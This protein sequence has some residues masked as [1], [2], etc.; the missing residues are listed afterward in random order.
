MTGALSRVLASAR[1][2]RARVAVAM[3][4]LIVVGCSNV[5]AGTD[6]S[7]VGGSPNPPQGQGV[8]FAQCM[9]DNG[10][11]QFP[12]P[13]ASGAFTIETVANGTSID[14][15]SPAFQRAI[16][17]CRNLEPAGFAGATRTPEQQQEALKFAQCIRDNGVTDF[18]DPAMD[19]PLVD[20]TRI[21]SSA[22]AAGM[23]ILHAAM[24]K[25]GALARS[26]GVQP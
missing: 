21:P 8:K 19:G 22:T 16:T 20:T 3:V 11:S 1:S 18:P 17:A 12:D 23:S 10:V 13:D 5:P 26:A 24:Q 4:A 6:A 2:A 9:R 14:T 25:C 7:S 15:N